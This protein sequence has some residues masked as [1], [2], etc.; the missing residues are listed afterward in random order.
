MTHEKQIAERLRRRQVEPVRVSGNVEPIWGSFSIFNSSPGGGL[1]T[2][3]GQLA[4]LLT[5]VLS[6]AWGMVESSQE[7]CVR[8][9]SEPRSRKKRA[10]VSILRDITLSGQAS[11]QEQKH[12]RLAPSG[13]AL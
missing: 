12:K 7:V 9:S 8:G 10:P 2:S 11:L 6:D 3:A 13:G 4:K 1:H 5:K